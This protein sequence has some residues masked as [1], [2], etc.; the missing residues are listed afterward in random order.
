VL[1][2]GAVGRRV[3]ASGFARSSAGVV[4]GIDARAGSDSMFGVERLPP[5]VGVSFGL[6][7][8]HIRTAENQPKLSMTTRR[9]DRW[10]NGPAEQAISLEWPFHV[11]PRSITTDTNCPL[12]SIGDSIGDTLTRP[13]LALPGGLGGS[14]WTGL[15]PD[16]L[17]RVS[18]FGIRLDGMCAIFE[19]HMGG[20]P[21]IIRGDEGRGRPD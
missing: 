7:T 9:K 14:K 19:T 13:V 1:F 12:T 16:L 4:E 18:R 20:S 21:S 11:V 5:V 8:G 17:K 3:T 15:G 2:G 10:S 6:Q